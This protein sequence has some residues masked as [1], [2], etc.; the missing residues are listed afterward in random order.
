MLPTDF[1]TTAAADSSSGTVAIG[2]PDGAQNIGTNAYVRLQFSKPVDRTSVN[3][4]TVSVTADSDSVPVTFTYNLSGADIVGANVYPVNPL[5]PSTPVI[6][7]VNGVLDY[8]GNTFKS[9]AMPPVSPVTATFTT[10][11]L[12]D[13]TNPSVTLDFPWYQAG[14]STSAS[15]TCHYS[16]P[17][18]PSSL[19]PSY[20]YIYSY[21]TNAGVPVN[22][23]WSTDM[24][25]LTMTPKTQLFANSQYSYQCEGAIDLTGNSQNFNWV[26]FYTGGTNSSAGPKLVYANPPSGMTNVPI[27]TSE[28][29]WAGSSLGLL[30]NEPVSPES[31]GNIT[32]TQGG[33]AMPISVSAQDGN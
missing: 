7:S 28:G 14:I 11:A 3:S 19:N 24:M 5:P 20:T 15:F 25:S 8:A 16:E 26:I 4:N 6:V 32:L 12:P 13:L 1:T 17:M 2:P 22:Y 23:A 30:F 18:D 31:M 33:S 10:A 9:A 27:N 29:P 21:V